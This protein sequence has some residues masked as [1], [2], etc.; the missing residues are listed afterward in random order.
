M[1]LFNAEFNYFSD[2]GGKL[3]I[4]LEIDL[5][6]QLFAGIRLLTDFRIRALLSPQSR[7]F[8]GKNC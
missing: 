3:Y 1:S 4:S 2:T 5:D 8:F 6:P 7:V